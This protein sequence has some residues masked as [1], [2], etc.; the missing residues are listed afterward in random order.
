MKKFLL[1]TLSAGLFSIVIS[2]SANAALVT[3]LG[4]LAVYDTDFD[5]T[6]IA[7]ANLADTNAF[8]V[9][10]INANGTM[11]WAKANEWI[12]AMNADSGAG[13]LGFSDWRLPTTLQPDASCDSQLN[14]GGFDVSFDTNCTGSEMGHLFYDELGGVAETSI[15]TTHNANFDLFSNIQAPG[16]GGVLYW[17]SREYAPDPATFAWGFGFFKGNQNTD[18]KGSLNP[19]WAVRSGDVGA[20]PIPAAAWLFSSGLIGLI[21]IARKRRAT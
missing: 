6:W 15:L 13:Y 16:P 18:D 9:A 17:S 14:V 7:D 21:G 2:T 19:A 12:T 11:V 3:R 1:G 20:V 5:I 8:G 10:G 4:G